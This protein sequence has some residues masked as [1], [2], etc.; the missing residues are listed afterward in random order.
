[1][2]RI[3]NCALAVVW[4]AAICARAATVYGIVT[5]AG[6]VSDPVTP[7][8]GVS[9]VAYKMLT[10]QSGRDS[11]R[12]PRLD[13]VLTGADGAYTLSHLNTGRIYL[14]AGMKG[15][16]LAKP[17]Y[18]GTLLSD[19]GRYIVNFLFKDTARSVVKVRVVRDSAQGRPLA[20]VTLIMTGT[21][22]TGATYCD[23]RDTVKTD[24]NG[25]YAFKVAPGSQEMWAKLEGFKYPFDQGGTVLNLKRLESRQ[26]LLVL[27]PEGATGSI[28]GKV[29]KA[30]DGSAVSRAK[31]ILTRYI[32]SPDGKF[33]P[34]DS[35]TS[36]SDGS[37]KFSNVPAVQG[38]GLTVIS[39]G[40]QTLIAEYFD[41]YFAR[42]FQAPIPLYPALA[43]AD[44]VGSVAGIVSDTAGNAL[45]GAR[46]VYI[47]YGKPKGDTVESDPKGRF[48]FPGVDGLTGVLRISRPGY[49]EQSSSQL[50]V[51]SR[52]TRFVFVTMQSSPTTAAAAQAG[53]QTLRWRS[54]MG[55]GII[56]EVPPMALTGN[57]RVY[58]L[59]GSIRFSCT[60]RA[61]ATRLEIPWSVRRTGYVVVQRGTEFLRAAVSPGP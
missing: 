58:D 17:R 8:S 9:V 29:A 18:T 6:D 16:I 46:V 47:D 26:I 42:T 45:A 25:E 21:C 35:T 20:G 32:S 37:Y 60:L 49:K 28:A 10:D 36:G 48:Y 38:Y 22:D 52:Q 15:Y 44:T 39:D 59:R 11:S 61:G 14:E 19:T 33:V 12:G 55:G 5:L 27:W 3:L 34:V 23:S 30:S 31:V 2:N 4:C 40:Y 50:L 57:V 24:A 43:R 1:M 56:L 41:V 13:S 53:K 7:A 51:Y 54:G